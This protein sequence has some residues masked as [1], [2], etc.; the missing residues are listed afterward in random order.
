MLNGDVAVTQAKTII[1][2]ALHE[3]GEYW[4]VEELLRP[5]EQKCCIL[6]MQ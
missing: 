4:K 1:Q 6:N 3:S 5:L 2:N